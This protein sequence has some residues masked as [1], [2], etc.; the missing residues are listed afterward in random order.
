MLSE[1][2]WSPAIFETGM[3]EYDSGYAYM[4]LAAAQELAGL[5]ARVTGIEVRTPDRWMAP[6]VAQQLLD[7]A[8][9]S[10][11]ARST[12]RSRTDR[13]S[14]R[15]SSRSSAMGVILLL[16]VL[17]AAFNIVSTLTMVVTDKTREIG[18]LQ[19]DG[20][21]VRR[22][23]GGSS[24]CRGWSIGV[25]GTGSA[26]CSGLSAPGRSTRFRLIGSIRRCI[27]SI[28]CRCRSRSAD[29]LLIALASLVIAMLATL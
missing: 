12:G 2:S 24:C 23:S 9:I 13:S 15:S 22:P 18:I 3:Y 10:R 19:G 20:H 29:V 11:I 25:V 5:G 28:T 6:I 8:R 26:C 1:V 17:V 27:S 16:I 4:E 14:R 7:S 21:A